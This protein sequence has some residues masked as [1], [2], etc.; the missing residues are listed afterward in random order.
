MSGAAAA[1]EKAYPAQAGHRSDEWVE[2]YRKDASLLGL[3][4]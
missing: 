4:T 2:R 3:P 1:P